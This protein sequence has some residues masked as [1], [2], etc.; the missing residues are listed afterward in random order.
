MLLPLHEVSYQRL[1]ENTTMFD[2][3]LFPTYTRYPISFTRGKGSWLYDKEGANYVD[4]ASGIAVASFGHCHPKLVEALC[5]QAS[6]LWHVSNLVDIPQ[7]Q[8]LAER[9]ASITFADR[10]FFANSGAEANECAIKSARKYQYQRGYPGR[11]RILTLQNAFHGRTLGTI[12]ATGQDKYLEGFGP[13]VDGF[14]TLPIENHEEIAAWVSDASAAI[15]IEPIQGEGGV[16]VISH[17]HLIFLRQLCDTHGLLLIFDEVQTGMGRTGDLFAYSRSGVTPDILTVAKGLGGGFPIGACLATNDVAVAMGPGSHASTFGGN[18]LAMACGNV[19]LD[20]LLERDFFKLMGE[21]ACYVRS[22]LHDIKNSFPELIS[23]IRGVG[24]LIGI[25]VSVNNSIFISEAYRQGL[26]LVGG[27][28]N[29]V[30]ILPALN[31][32]Q[33][34]LKEGLYRLRCVCTE[35]RRNALPNVEK[36]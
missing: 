9:L 22:E 20:L 35:I 25:Q 31:I 2:D 6:M 7:S 36:I 14:D 23:D 16:K 18:P 8:R 11:Y 5:Q 12:A 32:P 1:W 4:F 17:E 33:E 30:R 24:L 34:D 19:V 29:T 10:V 27:G 21:K 3:H 26:V 28:D 15:M 13:K